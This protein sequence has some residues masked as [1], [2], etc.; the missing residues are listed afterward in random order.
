MNP[1]A[2]EWFDV[3]NARDEVV[4]RA[5]RREVHARGLLHRAVH[6][7]VFDAAGRVLLQKR[8]MKKDMSPGLWDSSCSGHVDAGEDYDTA[9]TRELGEEIGIYGA[10]PARWFRLEACAETAQ[11]FC[12]VY[13][14]QH[15]G[16]LTLNA[17]EIERG[18]W[19]APAEIS[20]RVAARP[21]EYCAAFT[22][23]WGI[24]VRGGVG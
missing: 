21:E 18:E 24:A 8:S 5:T 14:L 12:W 15:G 22:L 2:D 10:T 13:R 4:G 17:D 11:E 16:P 3:V 1:P 7:L 9:A 6:V 20:A 19:V 23:L